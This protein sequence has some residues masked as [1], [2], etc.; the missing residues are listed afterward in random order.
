LPEGLLGSADPYKEEV[1]SSALV[2]FS[3]EDLGIL[4]LASTR[5]SHGRGTS[6]KRLERFERVLAGTK[7][8]SPHIALP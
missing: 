5:K 3:V 1:G 4:C 8:P 6:M 2:E 7:S